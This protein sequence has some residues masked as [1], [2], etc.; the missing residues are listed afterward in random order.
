MKDLELHLYKTPNSGLKT[1]N[2]ESYEGVDV[3]AT[4]R[5]N[6]TN[7]LTKNPSRIKNYTGLTSTIS[8]LFFSGVGYAVGVTGS[9]IKDAAVYVYSELPKI[10]NY[11]SGGINQN[12]LQYLYNL[13]GESLTRANYYGG[14]GAALGLFGGAFFMTKLKNSA[15]SI[16]RSITSIFKK[17]K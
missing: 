12:T 13:F 8:G 6:A 7:R 17:E 3:N 2:T 9:L 14:M 16:F 4:D 15:F 11:I 1:P 10:P 5:L